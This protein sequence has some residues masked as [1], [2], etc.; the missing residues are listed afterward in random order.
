MLFWLRASS[1][2]QERDNVKL[3]SQAS[4]EDL[5]W[6]LHKRGTSN[7]AGSVNSD[8]FRHLSCQMSNWWHVMTLTFF[9]DDI[10]ES[11][12]CNAVNT[13]RAYFISFLRPAGEF[14]LWNRS[15]IV[16]VGCEILHGEY[17][18][19]YIFGKMNSDK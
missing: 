12:H 14:A 17:M 8:A 9:E 18:L 1:N 15:N 4:R 11:S 19:L 6:F 5:W 2:S 7:W 13:S 3:S 16:S 10:S